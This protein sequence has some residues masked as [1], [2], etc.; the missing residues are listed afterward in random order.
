MTS[1][2][3]DMLTAVKGE[4]AALE[5][6]EL[7]AHSP[8]IA[9][10]EIIAECL[11]DEQEEVWEAIQAYADIHA[12]AAVQLAAAGVEPPAEAKQEPVPSDMESF[13]AW[14]GYPLPPRNSDG[15]FDAEPLHREWRAFCA[16]RA[17]QIHVTATLE[18]QQTPLRWITESDYKWLLQFPDTGSATVTLLNKGG[19]KRVPMFAG[20]RPVAQSELD[21]DQRVAVEFYAANPSAA[22]FDMN[23]RLSRNQAPSGS[24][25]GIPPNSAQAMQFLEQYGLNLA[26]AGF[27][28]ADTLK[29]CQIIFSTKVPQGSPTVA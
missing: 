2:K 7:P 29:A 20:R 23:L 27:S 25:G 6:I 10:K 15:Q 1:I 16:G 5:A 14:K 11:P 26:A 8:T 24:A 22:L 3:K 13:E 9:L 21:G 19:G 18:G 28:Q 17:S 12:R 4:L